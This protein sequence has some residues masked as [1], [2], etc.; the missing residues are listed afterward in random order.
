MCMFGRASA[1]TTLLEQLIH[2]SQCS[3]NKL[4]DKTTPPLFFYL[5]YKANVL[6]AFLAICRN[7]SYTYIQIMHKQST[8]MIKIMMKYNFIKVWPCIWTAAEMGYAVRARMG[9]ARED[10]VQEKLSFLFPF[11]FCFLFSILFSFSY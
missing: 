5:M 1:L 4:F 3:F 11:Y 6:S 7:T 10:L 9:R 2:K 8:T